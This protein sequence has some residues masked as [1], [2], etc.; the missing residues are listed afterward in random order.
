MVPSSAYFKGCIVVIVITTII[1]TPIYESSG[2]GIV[3]GN[4]VR[5]Y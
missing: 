3:G 2:L 1:T 5:G 4:N